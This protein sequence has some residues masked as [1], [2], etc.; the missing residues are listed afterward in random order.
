MALNKS[1]REFLGDAYDP[2]SKDYQERRKVSLRLF[3]KFLGANTNEVNH[4][5]VEKEAGCR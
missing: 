5:Q 2:A 4:E 1:P 3:E